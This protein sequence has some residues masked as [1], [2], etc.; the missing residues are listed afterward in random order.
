[1]KAKL[2]RIDL[3][4]AEHGSRVYTRSHDMKG[5]VT[6]GGSVDEVLAKMPEVIELTFKALGENVT[7]YEAEMASGM[8]V[9]VPLRCSAM[10][11]AVPAGK[12]D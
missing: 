3:D 2:I 8:R 1:M 11:V 9:D 10:F 4:F 7:V 12:P 5:L 6:S